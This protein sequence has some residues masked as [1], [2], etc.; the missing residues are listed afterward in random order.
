MYSSLSRCN[1]RAPNVYSLR[2]WR[3]KSSESQRRVIPV[4]RGNPGSAHGMSWAESGRVRGEMH[5]RTRKEMWMLG[6]QWPAGGRQKPS[7][8]VTRKSTVD[9]FAFFSSKSKTDG[10][11]PQYK[12]SCSSFARSLSV[13]R[14]TR[15]VRN[16]QLS[17][18]G[19]R[20]TM[21]GVFDSLHLHLCCACHGGAWL[22]VCRKES[23]VGEGGW[24]AL[25]T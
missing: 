12:K 9:F 2:E 11:K 1:S 4:S 3:G 16:A 15:G 14:K 5:S 20:R 8:I 19:V 22:L 18:S 24:E 13:S 10:R 7:S 23:G 17:K 6:W 21:Q 25:K